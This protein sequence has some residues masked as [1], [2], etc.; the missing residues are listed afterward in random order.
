MPAATVILWVVPGVL[1]CGLLALVAMELK[2]RA[3][4][5]DEWQRSVEMFRDHL[6]IVAI[7]ADKADGWVTKKGAKNAPGRVVAELYVENVRL[8]PGS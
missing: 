3:D 7:G 8:K 5:R 6:G 4:H 2:Q 1:G